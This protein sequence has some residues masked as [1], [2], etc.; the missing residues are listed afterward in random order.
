MTFDFAV[1][2]DI[3][4]W[5]DPYK[6]KLVVTSKIKHTDTRTV[7]NSHKSDWFQEPFETKDKNYNYLY[8]QNTYNV[9]DTKNNQKES[10]TQIQAVFPIESQMDD[11]SVIWECRLDAQ[12]PVLMLLELNS[13]CVPHRQ[14]FLGWQRLIPQSEKCQKW[15]G[16]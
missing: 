4:L 14:L 1:L 9:S 15:M 5:K 3:F 10:C 6:Q 11:F 7:F 13:P 8:T 2:S 12:T 16:K